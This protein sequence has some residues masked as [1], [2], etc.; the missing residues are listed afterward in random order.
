MTDMTKNNCQGSKCFREKHV[1]GKINGAS[2]RFKALWRNKAN[3]KIAHHKLYPQ[4]KQ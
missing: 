3:N 4:V 2:A 1:S